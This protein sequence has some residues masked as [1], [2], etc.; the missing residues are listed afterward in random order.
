M[1]G[2]SYC[3]KEGR[4]CED[5][6]CKSSKYLSEIYCTLSE[7]EHR[8]WGTKILHIKNED[9]ENV[10]CLSF[11]TLPQDSTGVAHILEHVVL[12]GSK[13]FPIRD[14]FFSMLYR[15]LNTFMNAFTGDDFTCYPA[16]SEV[17]KDFYH[18]LEIYLDAVFSPLIRKESFS[19]EGHRWEFVDLP[20]GSTQLQRHGV[21]FNEMKGALANAETR[22]W[23]CLKGQLFPDN[24][25]HFNSGGDPKEIPQLTREKMLAFHHQFYHPSQALLYFYGNLPIERHF[26]FLSKH[27]FSHFPLKSINLPP[28]LEEQK[29]LSQRGK[30]AVG[31]PVTIDENCDE[32]SFVG[33]GWVTFCT[34]DQVSLLALMILDSVLM[35]NDASLLKEEILRSGLCKQVDSLIEQ[36]LFQIPYVLVFKGCRAGVAEQLQELVLR[37]FDQLV[38]QGIEWERIERAIDQLEIER[39]E[40]SGDRLPYG[41]SLFMRCGLLK[42]HGGD[43]KDAL[44]IHTLFQKVR[45]LLSK[46]EWIS[47]FIRKYFIENTHRSLVI[48]FPDKELA[49]QEEKAEKREWKEI[50]EELSEEQ[51]EAIFSQSIELKKYQEREEDSSILPKITLRDVARREKEYPLERR[52]WKGGQCFYHHCF[53]NQLVYVDLYFSLPQLNR[54]EIFFAKLLSLL[55]T[56]LGCGSRSYKEQLE[57]IQKSTGGISATVSV[58]SSAEDP[59]RLFPCFHL[60]ALSLSRKKSALF[61]LLQ[62]MIGELRLD[63]EPRMYK[64]LVQHL[65]DLETHFVSHSM[66]Y[67]TH[68]CGSSLSLKGALDEAWHGVS[69]LKRLHALLLHWEV[70]KKS[71]LIQIKKIADKILQIGR[72]DLVLS[73]CQTDLQEIFEQDFYGLGEV[74]SLEEFSAWEKFD[75]LPASSSF[76]GVSIPSPVAFNC[77]GVPVPEHFHPDSAALAILA[78]LLQQ[79]ELHKKIREEGGAYGGK[80]IYKPSLG[81]MCFW[82]YRDPHILRTFSV[83]SQ[84]VENLARGN[85]SEQDLEE[86]QL[87]VFQS[88]DAPINPGDRAAVAYQWLQ[89]QKTYEKRQALREKVFA[90]TREE[91]IRVISQYLLP[92]INTGP[93]VSFAGEELFQKENETLRAQ[94]KPPLL[95]EQLLF[96]AYR[97]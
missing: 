27:L 94:N 53:T 35:D 31:Y 89:E 67:A 22:L 48:L 23:E 64:V 26:A 56:E 52:N 78:P 44:E 62:G 86:A 63:E 46:P 15:S 20:D 4:I 81:M 83:I 54:D 91:V 72:T 38:E 25:Y 43:P 11:R 51:K 16:A 60:H 92:Y 57:E 75:P 42:Q 29:S 45:T 73:A 50:E 93:K 30:C 36:D 6:L 10:F 39:L 82:G 41:L 95:T 3:E 97:N 13:K 24:V 55:I 59:H 7:W 65:T 66:Q 68:I 47:R 76:Q 70:T 77:V 9:V 21:V 14:P 33:L 61:S 2:E 69:F 49:L 1:K 90:L 87:Q 80:A 88:L 28:P 37:F 19:Q 5:F 85:F 17:E 32:K 79:K 96:S 12:C 8:K 71:F 74:R 40:I 34:R 18:L 84:A 58:L